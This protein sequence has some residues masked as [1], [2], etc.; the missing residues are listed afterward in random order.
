MQ[1]DPNFGHNSDVSM[2]RQYFLW[3]YN[4]KHSL[5]RRNHACFKWAMAGGVDL[6]SIERAKAVQ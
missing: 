6:F 1:N 4:A 3:G 5:H 2:R